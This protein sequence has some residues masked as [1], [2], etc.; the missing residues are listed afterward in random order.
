MLASLSIEGSLTGEQ[1]LELLQR[2]IIPA[3]IA[4]YSNDLNH[5]LPVC[6]EQDV[7]YFII[8]KQCVIMWTKIVHIGGLVCH[9]M[10]SEISRPY[11]NRLF[12][13]SYVKSSIK[14]TYL[15]RITKNV[16]ISSNKFTDRNSF[17]DLCLFTFILFAIDGESH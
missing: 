14:D 8:S 11:R 12:Q 3:I 13:W 15:I 6:F 5:N 16:K 4:M 17:K 1:Y 2:H 9:R 7:H 10:T